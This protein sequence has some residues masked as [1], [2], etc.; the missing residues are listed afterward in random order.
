MIVSHRHRF[1]FLKTSKTA[2]TSIEIALARFC[3]P[4]DIITPV[5]PE[6]EPL[7]RALGHPGPQ[8]YMADAEDAPAP[9]RG[10][11]LLSS[12]K[13]RKFGRKFYN[14]MPASEARLLLGEDIWQ[15]YFK[16]CVQRNPWDRVISAYYWQYRY[17]PKPSMRKFLESKYVSKLQD[18]GYLLYTI[19]GEPVVDRICRFEN[20]QEELESVR[21]H[22]GLPEPLELPRAKSRYRKDRRNYQEILGEAEKARIAE[23]FADEI[24]LLDYRY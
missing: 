12:G 6:D 15:S 16:F 14:H 22:I 4:D 18:R 1:I 21:R 11:S 9:L 10:L 2:G 5:S 19:N 3:D 8:H 17:P 13:R 24:R 23:L 7:R 20:L